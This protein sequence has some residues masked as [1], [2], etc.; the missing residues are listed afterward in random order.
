[1][2]DDDRPATPE[3][4]AEVYRL[5]EEA[6]KDPNLVIGGR[7]I[8][9]LHKLDLERAETM[10]KAYVEEFMDMGHF[11]PKWGIDLVT[12]KEYEPRAD[13]PFKV[14]P[15]EEAI[16]I[17][18]IVPSGFEDEESIPCATIHILSSI[19]SSKRAPSYLKLA[20]AKA[21]EMIRDAILSRKMITVMHKTLKPHETPSSNQVE[22]ES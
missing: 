22:S 7:P 17:A 20:G 1:M 13:V 11:G 10:L 19:L 14:A 18:T 12:I 15:I 21:A 4:I 16:C 6:A 2:N 5:L 9:K 8:M 3:D